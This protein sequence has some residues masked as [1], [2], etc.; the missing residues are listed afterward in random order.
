MINKRLIALVPTSMKHVRRKVYIQCIS[1]VFSIF[2]VFALSDFLEN[3]ENRGLTQKNTL[4]FVLISLMAI[5][6]RYIATV[7][8]G[9]EGFKASVEI[10]NVLRDKIYEKMLAIGDDYKKHVSTAEVLQNSIDGVEQLEIYFSSYLPQLFYAMAAPVIL[11]S[12]LSF[13]DIKSALVLLLCVPLIPVSI[14]A[15]QK[16]A[17]KII[18]KYWKQYMNLSDNFLENIQGLNTLKIYKSDEYKHNKMNE[19]AEHFRKIT[20]KVLMM[21]LNSIIMMDII[22]YGG[23]ALGVMLATK[24]YTSGNISLSGTLIIILLCAEF[25]L[26]LRLLGSFFHVAMNGMAAIEKI[27]SILDIE[28]IK[29]SG[30]ETDDFSINV[31]N[32][33]YTYS[34]GKQA[35]N[36]VDFIAGED[37]FIALVGRSGCGKSTFAEI[38]ANNYGD[39]NGSVKLGN[40]ELRN[41]GRKFIK[42]HITLISVSNYIFK[43]SVRD[44]LCMA[45]QDA[46]D[47]DMNE[48]LNKTN[49]LAFF[50]SKEGLETTITEAGSNLSGG[51]RQRLA[52]ARALLH[53]SDVYIF[54]EASSNIDVESEENIMS[55]LHALSKE[56]TVILISHRLANVVRANCIHVF[57]EGRIVERG[58]HKELLNKN[59]VYKELWDKQYELECCRGEVLS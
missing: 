7:L 15:I 50:N 54:D 13:I 28:D 29:D 43:G 58:T 10:K 31:K 55:I 49:L 33:S 25:F 41:L 37:R 35:L 57:E 52:V 11:F 18:G 19:E 4:I 34:D 27:F 8:S 44:N 9:K 40:M 1:L 59:A 3:I 6:I 26:P 53:E 42:K 32:M 38:L 48:V 46:S 17:K 5:A 2:F 30:K 23:T 21:Q 20:M 56:K 16:F 51:Q 36:N 22:A 24:G 14:I 39:Y 47:K 12:V 45:K